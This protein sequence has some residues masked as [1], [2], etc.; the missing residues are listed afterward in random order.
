MR[1]VVEVKCLVYKEMKTKFMKSTGYVSLLLSSDFQGFTV[2][3]SI[4]FIDLMPIV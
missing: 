4:S 3:C 1:P 2:Q